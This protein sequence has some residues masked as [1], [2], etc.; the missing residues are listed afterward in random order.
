M[1]TPQQDVQEFA[2]SQL[3]RDTWS[4]PELKKMIADSFL[5]VQT[6]KDSEEGKRYSLLYKVQTSPPTHTHTHTLCPCVALAR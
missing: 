5:M 3:N 2:S 6:S 4:N 1:F